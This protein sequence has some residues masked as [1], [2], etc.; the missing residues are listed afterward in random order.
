VLRL[1]RSRVPPGQAALLAERIEGE[2]RRHILAEQRVLFPA[3]RELGL[4]AAVS[5]FEL[6]L[7]P[8]LLRVLD[9]LHALDVAAPGWDSVLAELHESVDYLFG[10]EERELLQEMHQVLSADQAGELA[11]RMRAR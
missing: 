1:T 9:D 11:V 5:R 8:H 3:L 7:H 2:I 4:D 10:E 6:I